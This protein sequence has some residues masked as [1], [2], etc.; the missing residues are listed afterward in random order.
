MGGGGGGEGGGAIGLREYIYIQECLQQ[1]QTPT[2]FYKTDGLTV[3]D[4]G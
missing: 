3:K 4:G 2:F 1:C